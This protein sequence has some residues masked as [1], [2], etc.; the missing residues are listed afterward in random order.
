VT[1]LELSDS[2][3]LIEKEKLL[4]T[5]PRTS[6]VLT[7]ED[8]KGSEQMRGREAKEIVR[9]GRGGG[10]RVTGRICLDLVHQ[11]RSQRPVPAATNRKRKG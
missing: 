10:G 6:L 7:V 1:T 3:W 9:V 8:E 2:M 5:K 4:R 11:H